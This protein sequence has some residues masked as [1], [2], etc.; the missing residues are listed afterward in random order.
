MQVVNIIDCAVDD[1][2]G[3]GEFRVRML[4]LTERL[5]ASMIGATVFEMRAEET[6]GPYHFHHGIEEW[7]YVVS[8]A[9]S[10]ATGTANGRWSLESF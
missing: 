3:R 8:G 1:E 5:G 10:C 4:D 2:F 7:L 6:L 9:H